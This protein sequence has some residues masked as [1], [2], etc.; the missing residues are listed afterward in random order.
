MP[1][2]EAVADSHVARQK[3]IALKAAKKLAALW[4][5]TDP[6]RMAMSWRELIPEAMSVLA[7]GQTEAAAGAT[8]YVEQ[9]LLAQGLSFAAEGTLNPTMLAGIASDGREVRTLLYQPVISMLTAVKQGQTI[10]RAM[11]MGLSSLDMISRTQI[12]DAGRAAESVAMTAR[13]RVKGY[14]RMLSTPSCSRCI[15]LAGKWFKWND[16]FRRHP[17]CD[18]RHIPS[19]EN[20]DADVR[21]D[22]GA[23]F[24]SMS[25]EQQDKSFGRAGAEAIRNGADINQVVN[26]RRGMDT[27]TVFGK[28]VTH[29]REGVTRYGSAGQRLGK[30]PVRL[31]PE[32]IL[33]EANGN[34]EEAIRLLRLYAYIR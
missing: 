29:T 2:L 34:R 3:R 26:A 28:K 18:C 31:M 13:P 33:K 1:T 20:T 30:S 21:T 12:S 5:R 22:P 15:I 6:N 11:A 8:L 32:Q 17:R 7:Q 4:R 19:A 23:L 27:A 14:V 25:A 16:G 10:P 24:Q 9:A